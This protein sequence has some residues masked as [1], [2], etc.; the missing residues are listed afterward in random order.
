MLNTQLYHV[1]TSL[2]HI[3]TGIHALLVFI[4]LSYRSP[5][6]L[7]VPSCIPVTWIFLVTDI[8]IPVTGYMSCWY[9]MCGILHLLFPVSRYPVLCYQQSSCSLIILLVPC[10][11]LVLDILYS[12]YLYSGIPVISTVMPASGETCV[13]LSATWS[14]VP[15]HT[16]P[17][18][19]PPLESV[20]ATSR[21]LTPPGVGLRGCL[22][23]SCYWYCYWSDS[24]FLLYYIPV[25]RTVM[26]TSGTWLWN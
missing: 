24:V 20:G 1:H 23:C 9:A 11:V 19:G 22:W 26:L 18:W 17:W 8:D 7:H 4:F 5:F 16:Y 10:T 2:L 21:V 13:E 25:I 15:H 14:K 6:I 3:F 12:S